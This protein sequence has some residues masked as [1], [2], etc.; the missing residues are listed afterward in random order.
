MAITSGMMDGQRQAVRNGYTKI[1]Q[2]VDLLTILLAQP[3]WGLQ[4]TNWDCV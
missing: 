4:C 2:G 3:N 1:L